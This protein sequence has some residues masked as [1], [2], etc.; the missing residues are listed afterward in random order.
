M[1]PRG[2]SISPIRHNRSDR[3]G[4]GAVRRPKPL[5]L[6]LPRH[7]RSASVK[8]RLTVRAQNWPTPPPAALEKGRLFR[9]YASARRPLR[10]DEPRSRGA[11]VYD[12][13]TSASG[14]EAFPGILRAPCVAQTKRTLVGSWIV[15]KQ[16]TDTSAAAPGD[17]P[18]P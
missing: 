3:A 8:R 14:T 15:G 12:L 1:S 11:P 9:S 7:G 2:R 13:T 10:W 5:L 16:A 4:R 18:I 6:W 17:A